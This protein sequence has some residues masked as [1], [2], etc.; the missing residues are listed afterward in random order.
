ML[1]HIIQTTTEACA[2][3]EYIYMWQ[4]RISAWVPNH[5]EVWQLEVKIHAFLNSQLDK[6]ETLAT[7]GRIFN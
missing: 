1:Q 6:N 5:K 4:S 7:C 3:Y 2:L